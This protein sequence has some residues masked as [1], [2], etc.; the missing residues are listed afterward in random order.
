M[1]AI[2]AKALFTPLEKVEHPLVLIDGG[3]IVRLSSLS[4]SEIPGGAKHIDFDDT[5]LAPGLLDLHVHGA[6]GYDL[7]QDDEGGRAAFE[8][9]L[10][11]HG[12]TSYC[13]T[14]LTASLTDTLRAL[15][16]LGRA[17]EQ[18]ERDGENSR[19]CP[20]GSLLELAAWIAQRCRTE[21]ARPCR[22]RL[23]TRS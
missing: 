1:L 23:R 6:V 20:L 14:T 4:S 12:V 19:A 9:F 8:E 2:T 16:R 22:G 18:A 3:K 7:M 10:L 13:P 11:R 21:R 17:V 15:E 5:I